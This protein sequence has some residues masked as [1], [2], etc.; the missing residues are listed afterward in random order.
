MRYRIVLYDKTIKYI[1]EHCSTRYDADGHPA[2][3]YGTI[4]D[5]T[6]SVESERQLDIKEKLLI[7][8]SRLA[9]MGSMIG[10]IAHQW[11]QPINT[12]SMLI[13]SLIVKYEREILDDD[14][15]E[16]FDQKT[17][18]QILLMSNTIDDFRNFFKPTNDKSD[19]SLNKAI[20]TATSLLLILLTKH[21]VDLQITTDDDI[22]LY[23]HQNEL[24]QVIINIIH[25]AID[26]MNSRK[27]EN[28][29]IK[30]ITT[31]Y[32]DRVKISIND[33]GGGIPDDVIGKV[34]DPYFSTK[35][36]FKGTG[37][38]LFMCKMII[39]DHMNGEIKASNVEDGA[40]F[41]IILKI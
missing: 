29:I 16:V 28:K 8:Q 10:M 31:R 41:E 9:E 38:G 17:S 3:S 1:E 2:I 23:G 19:F 5:I 26:I 25:N 32:E 7:E 15:I 30:I 34:F 33:N 11:R 20:N 37:L 22:T 39:E 12:I 6:A 35:D 14:I 27:I 24:G 13:Q 4:Q 21:K 18:E 40:N 36:E